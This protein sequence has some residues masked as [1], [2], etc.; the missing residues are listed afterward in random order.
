MPKDEYRNPLAH[1]E[2]TDDSSDY[3]V[4]PVIFTRFGRHGS[5]QELVCSE[6]L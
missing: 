2:N 5:Q 3:R 4:D 6:V 1:D